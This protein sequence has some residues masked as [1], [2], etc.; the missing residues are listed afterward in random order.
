MAPSARIKLSKIA[1][2]L[3]VIINSQLTLSAQ[4]AAVCHSCCY[5]TYGSSDCL[6]DQCYLMPSRLWSRRSF[7]ASARHYDRIT[8]VLQ[9]L[10]WL[11]VW[12]W[13]H[14]KMVTLVYLSLSGMA[15][16]YLAADCQLSLMKVVVSCVLPTQGHVS[17]AM[18]WRQMFCCCRSKTEKQSSSSSGTN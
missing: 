4:V 14:F 2:D 6:S 16:A 5:T 18:E 1:Q 12:L 10:H 15:P 13:V 7:H 17:A 8:L 3:G 11:P 9:E